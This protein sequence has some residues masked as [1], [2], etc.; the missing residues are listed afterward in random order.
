MGM[1]ERLGRGSSDMKIDPL[2]VDAIGRIPEGRDIERYSLRNGAGLRADIMTYG[3]TLMRLETPDRHGRS[4]NIVLGFDTLAPYLASTPCFGATVGRFANRIAGARFT[5]NGR[6]Y[7]LSANEGENHL[8]GG[9][10]GFDTAVWEASPAMRDGDP[11]VLLRYISRNGEEGYPGELSLEA[12]YLLRPDRLTLEFEARTSAPT[13]VN[14]THHSYF[15]LSGSALGASAHDLC[16]DAD[17]FLAIDPNMIP[18]NRENV[19][20]TPFDFRAPHRI[21]ARIDMP[22]EQLRI[23]GGY[24]HT[25]VL[26]KPFGAFAKAAVLSEAVG[27]R[28]MSVWA[29]APGLQFYSGNHLDSAVGGYEPRAGLCLEPQF[30]PDSPNRPDF[31]STLLKPGDRYEARI[32]FVFEAPL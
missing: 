22:S 2:V 9:A 25:F 32:E 15:D 10:R 26:N 30:F 13:H 3:A 11:G 7:Q 12:L 20:G 4:A 31:P 14:I 27:G 24:D 1:V 28:R 18:R 17:T 19:G 16:I 8:H 6:T 5:L 21:G 29:T 23:A